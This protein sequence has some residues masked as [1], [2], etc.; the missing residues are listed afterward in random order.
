MSDGLQSWKAPDATNKIWSV[1]TLPN[2]LQH[3]TWNHKSVGKEMD[4]VLLVTVG[5][6]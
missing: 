2:R 4:Y 5:A 1:F 3:K 6:N